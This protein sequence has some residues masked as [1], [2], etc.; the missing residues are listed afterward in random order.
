MGPVTVNYALT[1]D[2]CVNGALARLGMMYPKKKKRLIRSAEFFLLAAGCMLAIAGAV[3]YRPASVW[4][5]AV[6]AVA[7]LFLVA[8]LQPAQEAAVRHM[9]GESFDSGH[10]GMPA[11][12]VTFGPR[13]LS[14]RSERYEA[15]IPYPMLFSAYADRNV[16]LIFTASDEW[17][18]VPR[19]AMSK[20]EGGQV[21]SLLRAGMK[22]KFKLEVA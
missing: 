7:G 4:S 6:L 17:R 9:A 20:E 16:F 19:R 2:D 15:E 18:I 14:V 3:L 12:T 21:Q 10:F 11:Q 13:G 1:R 5:G 8:F 22:E